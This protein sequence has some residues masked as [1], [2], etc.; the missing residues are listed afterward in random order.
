M[1]VTIQVSNIMDLR[2]IIAAL[3][4]SISV[5]CASKADFRCPSDD[6]ISAHPHAESCKKYYRCTF[7]QAEELSCPCTLYFDSLSRS[8]T[9]AGGKC[10]EGTEV[11][12]WSQLVS[13][14]DGII[15]MVP[16]QVICSKYYLCL[17][18]ITVERRCGEG[19]LF[20]AETSKCTYP[21]NAHCH[22]NPW[23]PEIDDLQNL[24]FVPDPEN[25]AR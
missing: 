17:G 20:D 11:E 18:S 22:L 7:G 15:K 14:N 24:R 8:C 5:T 21:G 23:C 13:V 9:H 16:H 6:D 1:K 3:I 2:V 10:A 25:C 12:K 19:L 4:L